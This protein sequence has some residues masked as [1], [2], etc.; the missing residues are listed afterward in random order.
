MATNNSDNAQFANATD[1]FTLAGGTTSRTLTVTGGNATLT[2]SGSNV[3][4]MPAATDTL[5]G[6]TST[7]TLTGKSIDGS[8]NTLT[9]IPA[10]ALA[11]GAIKLGY[12]QITAS[13]TG[14]TTLAQITGLSLTVTVPAGGRSIEITVYARDIF[15]ATA[16]YD[17]VSIWD[18]TVGTGTQLQSG[19]FY[20]A[21]GFAAGSVYVSAVVTP[22]AGS[23]TYNVGFQAGAGAPV[24]EAA[25]TYP[26]YILVKSI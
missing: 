7:D 10:S 8:T 3:Y 23:K 16:S 1:G 24:F 4:T 14:S 25:A 12:A 17:T 11:T 2:A 6:R 13:F 26:A 18:G 5:V 9:N 19:Q 22:A 15:N 20:K 21:A